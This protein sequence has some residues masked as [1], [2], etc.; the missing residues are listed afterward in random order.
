[1]LNTWIGLCDGCAG[2]PDCF[3]QM[4]FAPEWIEGTFSNSQHEMVNPELVISSVKEECTLL[5]EWKSG[6]NTEAD[7]LMRYAAVVSDDLVKGLHIGKKATA[8]HDIVVIC[9]DENSGRIRI[10]L[11][12]K[13]QFPLLSVD[14]QGFTLLSNHFSAGN[15]DAQFKPTLSIDWDLAPTSYVPLDH[16]SEF[17]EIAEAVVPVLIKFLQNRQPRVELD[18]VCRAVCPQ[19]RITGPPER[20]QFRGRLN[21]VIGSAC[22]EYLKDHM[23]IAGNRV[24]FHNWNEISPK[25][26]RKTLR[27]LRAAHTTFI[28][29]LRTGERPSLQDNLPFE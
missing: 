28:S 15:V 20:S 2:L 6:A 29:Y 9:R 1:M 5:F 22:K 14:L 10:G 3:H 23:H 25:Q 19:W 12:N 26:R 8:K 21:S 17:W 11:E 4:G 18:D 16:A 24:V 27:E 7:Q 13:F